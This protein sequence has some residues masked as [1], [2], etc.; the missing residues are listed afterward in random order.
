[1]IVDKLY[2]FLILKFNKVRTIYYENLLVFKIIENCLICT[3]FAIAITISSELMQKNNIFSLLNWIKSTSFLLC[4][5]L[6]MS[7]FSLI[8]LILNNKFYAGIIIAFLFQCL[9]IINYYKLKTLDQPLY[10]IDLLLSKELKNIYKYLSIEFQYAIFISILITF[11]G[12]I[13]LYLVDHIKIKVRH[14]LLIST[15]FFILLIFIFKTFLFND[16]NLKRIGIENIVSLPKDNYKKNGFIL[17]FCLNLKYIFPEHPDDYNKNTILSLISQDDK[18]AQ[19]NISEIQ[20]PNIIVIMNEAFWDV[21][22]F[23]N[24]NFIEDPLKNFKELKKESIYGYHVSPTFG[25]GTCNAEFEFLTGYSNHFLPVGSIPYQQ[26][27]KDNF[28]SIVSFLNDQGYKS[29]AIHPYYKWFWNRENVYKYMG[30]DD[31]ISLEDIKNPEIKGYFVSDMEV[32][33]QIINEYEQNKNKKLFLFCVTMQNHGPYEDLRYGNINIVNGNLDEKSKMILNTYT[34]GIKSVDEAFAYLVNYFRKIKRPTI[35]MIFGDHKPLLGENFYVYK[36]L[37]YI[38]NDEICLDVPFLIWKN[39]DK[40]SLNIG[41]FNTSYLGEI[42][43]EEANIKLPRYFQKLRQA[44]LKYP[45]F[46]REYYINQS[47]KKTETKNINKLNTFKELWELQYD[48]MF[49]KK[50]AKDYIFK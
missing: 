7:I 2:E 1:M 35:I 18:N 20:N 12:L 24:I 21:T 46:S 34:E 22:E 39:Y 48:M 25:G 36:K 43:L 26:Y 29:I 50:Y 33:K 13:I 3:L 4:V 8:A 17:T 15:V 45:I 9:S 47:G 31:F 37:N 6:I 28:E 14:R 5:V 49:G 30:F 11:I 19:S 40:K 42:L 44:K 23:N 38:T 32:S 41:T 16:Y 27:I 10:P